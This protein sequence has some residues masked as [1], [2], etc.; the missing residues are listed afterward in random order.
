MED[1]YDHVLVVQH[2]QRITTADDDAFELRCDP[3]QLKIVQIQTT[4]SINIQ[5]EKFVILSFLKFSTFSRNIRP[6]DI[7]Y[8]MSSEGAVGKSI[9]LETEKGVVILAGKNDTRSDKTNLL[10]ASFAKKQ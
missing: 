2:H 6:G 1:G 4:T 5:E 10:K 3:S 9:V 7:G 8:S